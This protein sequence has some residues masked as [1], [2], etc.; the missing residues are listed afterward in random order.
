MLG[1]LGGTFTR[2]VFHC[3]LRMMG[4]RDLLYQLLTM[5]T[6]AKRYKLRLWLALLVHSL[7]PTH[8]TH[9]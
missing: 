8:E 7:N 6:M 5:L 1:Q 4:W 9:T 3:R 2:D